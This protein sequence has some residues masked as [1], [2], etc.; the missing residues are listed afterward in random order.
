MEAVVPECARRVDRR[1]DAAAGGVQLLVRGA[2]GPQREFR[3]TV[4]APRGM[5]VAVDEARHRTEAAA[6]QL[7][8]VGADASERA[9]RPHGGDLVA[10]AEDV[11]IV[12]HG[13]CP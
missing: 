4:A 5:R 9:H 3:N 2:A 11:R 1:E 7:L 13:D 6:V 10:A 12:D 8:D